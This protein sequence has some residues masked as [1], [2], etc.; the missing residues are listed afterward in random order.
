[1]KLDGDPLGNASLAFFNAAT[2]RIFMI[3]EWSL[4][5]KGISPL[6]IIFQVIQ[7]YLTLKI[8]L[9]FMISGTIV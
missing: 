6:D 4:K 1:M 5:K 3:S 8:I 9:R 2:L 7:V